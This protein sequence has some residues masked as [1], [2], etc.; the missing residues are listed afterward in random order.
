MELHLASHSAGTILLG[1]MLDDI[2]PEAPTG[3]ATLFAPACPWASPPATM[4]AR[5]IA[6]AAPGGLHFHAL[7]DENERG[8][9][10]GPYGKSLLHL[11]SRALEAPRK[12]P[13]L[14]SPG[15][16]KR[17]TPTSPKSH[18][19]PRRGDRRAELSDIKAVLGADCA[20]SDLKDVRN[21]RD[22]GRAHGVHTRIAHKREFNTKMHRST[23]SGG[24]PQ[25]ESVKTAP[26]CEAAMSP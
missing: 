2:D 10:V 14:G 21:W 7:S 1:H 11:V 5:W 19:A 22:L 8:D 17:A 26:T 6:G 23:G 18:K 12:Q 9:K 25:Q 15:V 16:W 20:G 3:S 13:P 4:A 24:V